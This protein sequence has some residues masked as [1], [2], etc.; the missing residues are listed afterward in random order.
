LQQC[1][2]SPSSKA[3]LLPARRNFTAQLPL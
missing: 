3:Y 2:I 1:S